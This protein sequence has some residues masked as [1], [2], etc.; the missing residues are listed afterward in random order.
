M[1]ALSVKVPAPFLTSARL[2]PLRVPETVS[3]VGLLTVN[4]AAA[5]LSVTV[6]VPVTEATCWLNPPRSR[7]A[8]AALRLSAVAMGIALAMPSFSVPALTV[9]APT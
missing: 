8:A 6:P 1:A 7:V 2:A 3:A 4:V 5:P 9:V